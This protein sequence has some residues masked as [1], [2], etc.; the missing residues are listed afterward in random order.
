MPVPPQPR[1]S[2]PGACG[3][4]GDLIRIARYR[5]AWNLIGIEH[6]GF[7]VMAILRAATSHCRGPNYWAI[8]SD[9]TTIPIIKMS[10]RESDGRLSGNRVEVIER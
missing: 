2:P 4:D 7:R 1:G 10:N 8:T 6:L 3:H 5:R 9:G